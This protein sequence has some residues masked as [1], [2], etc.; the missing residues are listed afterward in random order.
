MITGIQH[1][2]S[3]LRWVVLIL[4]VLTL[5]RAWTNRSGSF[6]VQQAKLGLFTMISIHVQLLLGL[7]LYV[8]K[9]WMAKLGDSSI[10][11][12]TRDRFFTVEH[13]AGMLIAIVFG[14]LGHSLVKRASDDAVKYRRQLIYF[15]IALILILASIPWPIRPGFE[16]SGWF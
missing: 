10:M 5:I 8:Q 12:V 7:V 6:S 15:G 9:G 13:P 14:T 2:H 16:T 3:T 4:L 11:G 1:L